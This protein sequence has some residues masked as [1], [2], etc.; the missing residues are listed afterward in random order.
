[1]L[2]TALICLPLLTILSYL[3][4]DYIH[5]AVM[6][7]YYIAKIHED[8]NWQSKEFRFGWGDSGT[9]SINLRVLA[10]DASGKTV[11]G[12]RLNPAGD[13]PEHVRHLIGNFYMV[14]AYND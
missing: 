14:E 11:V 10:Y 8:P 2:S 13:L 7:P 4:G 3:L 5:L 12:E 1:V 6:Y 9:L